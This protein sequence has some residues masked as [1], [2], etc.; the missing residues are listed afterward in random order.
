LEYLAALFVTLAV[1]VPVAMLLAGSSRRRRAG[2]T[3]LAVNLVSH[4]IAFFMV[5][6]EVLPF[7]PTEILVT[8][9]E[10]VGYRR[11]ARLSPYRAALTS[12]LANGL[13]TALSFLLPW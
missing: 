10:A 6:H 2:A 11:F 12:V 5:T 4:P 1:E 7:A 8:V 9:F 3:S 13:T